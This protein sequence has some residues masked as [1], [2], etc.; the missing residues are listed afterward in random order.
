MS[1]LPEMKLS[2]FQELCENDLKE[3]PSADIVSEDGAYLGTFVNSQTD[4]IKLQAQYLGD[5][6]NGVTE[7]IAG[8]AREMLA[9]PGRNNKHR[10][11]GP[12]EK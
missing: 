7:K 3:L 5:Q 4:Y 10:D 9:G 1:L 6:S 8:R 11:Y 2:K 12:K